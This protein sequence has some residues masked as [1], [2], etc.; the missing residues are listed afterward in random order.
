[1]A[2]ATV[3]AAAR[4]AVD[5]GDEQWSHCN[6]HI[7]N[8]SSGNSNNHATAPTVIIANT[9]ITVPAAVALTVVAAE[10][11]LTSHHCDHHHSS[12]SHLLW[13]RWMRPVTSDTIFIDKR[14]SLRQSNCPGALS[15]TLHQGTSFR[16]L[17]ALGSTAWP[18][19]WHN[20][21]S[22][23]SRCSNTTTSCSGNRPNK[24]TLRTWCPL[25]PPQHRPSL[26]HHL[27]H[28]GLQPSLPL[29]SHCP[30]QQQ[31]QRR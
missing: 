4:R 29:H 18:C 30:Q 12:S 28:P 7:T 3:V 22:N 11:T 14:R 2:A 15:T 21:S 27:L 1:M 16:N 5:G 13:M 10:A 25:P 20:S 23:S 9:A 31:P 17:L 6:S 24:T 8:S 26:H 19:W